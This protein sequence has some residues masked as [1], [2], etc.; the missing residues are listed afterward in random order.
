MK[1]TRSLD[2]LGGQSPEKK[3]HPVLNN[4][5]WRA[6]QLKASAICHLL[7]CDFNFSE[8]YNEENT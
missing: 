1:V 6:A 3:S 2:R 4:K 7:V 5:R 8:L